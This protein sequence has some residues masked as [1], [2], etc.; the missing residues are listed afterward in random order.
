MT[1]ALR[2]LPDAFSTAYWDAARAGQLLIQWC[3]RCRHYQWYPRP[4]CAACLAAP[5]DWVEA[6]GG[7]TLHSYTV[8]HRTPNA[9]FAGRTPYVYA[10]VDLDEGVRITTAL[11]EI[12]DRGLQCG[13]RVR[14][15]F[16]RDT[17]D[18]VLPCAVLEPEP[19]GA[20]P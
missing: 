16:P 8:V 1:E 17:D 7:G 12:G 20:G 13:A 14:I 11:V 5:P 19:A 4:H 10:L 2:P 18:F 3:P 15:V 9:Q 6:S